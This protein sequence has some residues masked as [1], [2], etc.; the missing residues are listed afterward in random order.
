MLSRRE[1]I[2]VSSLTSAAVVTS[3]GT[4]VKE[5]E[6]RIENELMKDKFGTTNPLWDHGLGKWGC[7]QFKPAFPVVSNL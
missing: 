1:F 2:K 7:S 6:A 5:S 3:W 4:L